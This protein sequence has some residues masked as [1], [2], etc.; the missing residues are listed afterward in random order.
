M[1]NKMQSKECVGGGP[2]EPGITEAREAAGWEEQRGQQGQTALRAQEREGL[3]T[4]RGF[5]S[6]VTLTRAR[7]VGF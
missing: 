3:K 6:T 1:K 5:S 4:S 7:L 2:G